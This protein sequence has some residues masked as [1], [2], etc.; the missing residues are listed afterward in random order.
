MNTFAQVVKHLAVSL[1]PAKDIIFNHL[2]PV[3]I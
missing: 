3:S 1:Y 2:N